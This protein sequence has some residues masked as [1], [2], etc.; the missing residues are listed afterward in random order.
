[1]LDLE[2]GDGPVCL[3]HVAV[4]APRAAVVADAVDDQVDVLVV[5]VVMGDQDGS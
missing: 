4:G 5:G 3:H 2:G 1:V